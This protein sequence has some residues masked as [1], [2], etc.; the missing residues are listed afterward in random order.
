MLFAIPI[1]SLVLFS[2]NVI[3]TLLDRAK[4]GAGM[5]E[6]VTRDPRAHRAVTGTIVAQEQHAR[7]RAVQGSSGHKAAVPCICTRDFVYPVCGPVITGGN[8]PIPRDTVA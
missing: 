5:R 1:V 6:N 4:G 2:L 8:K 3:S 7:R